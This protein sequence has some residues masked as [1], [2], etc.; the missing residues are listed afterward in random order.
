MRN[1][2]TDNESSTLR[3][4]VWTELFPWLILV[5]GFRIAIQLR[6]L[7][8]G[9]FGVV[10]TSYGW[11]FLSWALVPQTPA[12]DQA[13]HAAAQL[14]A[15]AGNLRAN[16]VSVAF[17]VG[18]FPTVRN[19]F[20]SPW[21]D[22][23]KPLAELFAG[24][25]IGFRAAAHALLCGLWAIAVWSWFGA[26]IC[27]S[28]ALQLTTRQIDH[29]GSTLRFVR[30]KWRSFA[31]AP[32]IPLSGILAMAV[33]VA[34]LGA[35][36]RWEWPSLLAAGLWPL[37]LVC[38]LVM[39][40]LMLVLAFAWPLMWANVATEGN[41]CF[42]AVARAYD[43][44]LHRPLHY[45]FYACVAST[46]GAL[47]WLVVS[48]VVALVINVTFRAAGWGCG[49]ESLQTMMVGSAELGGAGRVSVW[50]IGFWNSVVQTVGSGFLYA[51][52]WTNSCAIYLLL[53]RDKDATEM[54]ECLA[55]DEDRTAVA[56]P[57]LKTDAMGAPV[58][59]ESAGA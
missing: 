44:T 29:L 52:F 14:A 17:P 11:I 2:M 48:T 36:L 31:A 37:L 40:L 25:E 55:E 47:S 59:D 10:L 21:N 51:F 18:S 32:L 54:D 7:V 20:L 50:L 9:A 6:H 43:Y 41:D 56:L 30:R 3:R 23:N 4:I 15:T 27:R 16:P 1:A 12:A 57:P 42:E 46:L 35:F 33:P 8:L 13:S 22:L 26:A 38:G 19:A 53:R 34:L 49:T 39:A 58:V 45:L 28:A 5:R 24:Q